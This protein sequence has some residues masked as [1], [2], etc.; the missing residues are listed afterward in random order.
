MFW[1]DALAVGSTAVLSAM[2]RQCR[3]RLLYGGASGL[4]SGAQLLGVLRLVF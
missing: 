4:H 2:L 3:S 1:P